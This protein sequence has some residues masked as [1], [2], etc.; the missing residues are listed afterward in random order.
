MMAPHEYKLILTYVR[1]TER[2][3]K[4]EAK[5]GKAKREERNEKKREKISNDVCIFIEATTCVCEL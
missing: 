3:R 1:L 2:A 5:S 4:G